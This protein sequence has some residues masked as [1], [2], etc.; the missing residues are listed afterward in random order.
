MKTDAK[1]R[2]NQSIKF[3]FKDKRVSCLSDLFNLIKY[4]MEY[5]DKYS[6]FSGEDNMELVQDSIV[7]LLFRQS[8]YESVDIYSSVLKP[9]I[10]NSITLSKSK[11][12]I[13]LKKG[14]LKHC[15]CIL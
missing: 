6:E 8:K 3:V 12:L 9:Y 5:V 1:I 2:A 15:V 7:S 10:E 14:C 11:I 13:N 4:L